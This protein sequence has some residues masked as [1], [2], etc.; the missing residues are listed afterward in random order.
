MVVSRVRNEGD[1]EEEEGEAEEAIG[2]QHKTHYA[3]V[4]MAHQGS[5]VISSETDLSS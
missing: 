4:R 5:Q 1:D 3:K 2:C